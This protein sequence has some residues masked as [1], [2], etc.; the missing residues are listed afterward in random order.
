MALIAMCFKL[1]QD[2][3]VQK[4]RWLGQK[5]GILGNRMFHHV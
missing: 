1:M 3:V 4:A 5:I 2:D